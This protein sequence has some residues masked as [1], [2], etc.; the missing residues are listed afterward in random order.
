[1][2]VRVRVSLSLSLPFSQ[3]PSLP[4]SLSQYPTLSL[5]S[6]PVS[7]PCVQD[8]FP[9]KRGG[10]LESG[11]LGPPV[12]P[13]GQGDQLGILKPSSYW[14][15]S[16]QGGVTRRGVVLTYLLSLVIGSQ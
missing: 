9:S 15:T 2:S 8:P 1:V 13:G 16:A 11:D 5:S 10:M 14:A 3:A 7:Y 12:V 6:S 4:P